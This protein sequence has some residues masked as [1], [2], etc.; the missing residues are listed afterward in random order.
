ME[1]FHSH[2]SGG[3]LTHSAA[4]L[5]R[6]RLFRFPRYEAATPVSTSLLQSEWIAWRIKR[7]G[8]SIDFAASDDRMLWCIAMGETITAV[9]PVRRWRGGRSPRGHDPSDPGRRAGRK[10]SVQYQVESTRERDD[11]VSV[12]TG[13]SRERSVAGLVMHRVIRGLATGLVYSLTMSSSGLCL[14]CRV[15]LPQTKQYRILFFDSSGRSVH[16]CV[17]ERPLSLSKCHFAVAHTPWIPAPP[18]LLSPPLIAPRPIKQ[19]P[20]HRKTV[21]NPNGVSP[22]RVLHAIA[23]DDQQIRDRRDRARQ[24]RDSQSSAVAHPRPEHEQ[25][26]A[27]VDVACRDRGHQRR[28]SARRA[29]SRRLLVGVRRFEGAGVRLGECRR[30]DRQAV[31]FGE[32]GLVCE[33][34]EPKDG[35]FGAAEQQR[36]TFGGCGQV[37]PEVLPREGGG[38]H[39]GWGIVVYWEMSAVVIPRVAMICCMLASLGLRSSG[40]G[41]NARNRHGVLYSI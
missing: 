24:H 16:H 23:L 26:D 35:D 12:G 28:L 36:E 1:S 2:T 20:A 4:N 19:T 8:R 41:A 7:R 39:G 9:A 15:F 30:H 32:F 6:T 21:E 27:V 31:S 22:H 25:Q 37:G 33:A 5:P 34:A 14:C 29:A 13:P 10:K 18:P 40:G 11:V 38:G 17:P 3:G